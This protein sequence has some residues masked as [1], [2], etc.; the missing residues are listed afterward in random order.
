MVPLGPFG[1][2]RRVAVAVSGGA[3]STALALLAS[4][5]GRAVALVVDHRL[6]PESAAQADLTLSRLAE[7]GIQARL[8]TLSGL[9][10]GP[11]LQARART[12]RYAALTAACAEAGLV[13][14]L[15][16]HHASDQAETVALRRASGSGPAGLAGMSAVR[17]TGP[18]RLL[19][20]L[21]AIPPARLRTTLAAAGMAWIE[22][23]SN[24][25]PRFT[26]GRLRT[27][28]PPP[29]GPEDRR[30]HAE[31]RD[32]WPEPIAIHPAG[33]AVLPPGPIPPGTLAAAIW[34]VS[35]RP[36]PPGQDAVA[37][38]T[39][40][41]TLHGTCIIVSRGRRFI[42]REEAATEPPVPALP[43]ARWDGR[44]V[45]ER[46]DPAGL[47][48]G[49][50]GD[51]AP[52]LRRRSDLP[53]AVLRVFPA[54]WRDGVLWAVPHLA[55]PSTMA[56]ASLRIAFRP[57]HPIAGSP[58]VLPS[59]ASGVHTALGHPMFGSGGVPGPDAGPGE[60]VQGL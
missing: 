4:S 9:V 39:G 55:Y 3:D 58:F 36:Y 15:L 52:A 17:V 35:G 38:T 19:R 1:A 13:D 23:P 24:T 5:W 6:R 7:R 41:S 11:G 48:L 49:R 46:C 21:L 25:D 40:A 44:F 28:P 20:P 30:R 16:G 37:R 32:P 8:L 51:G 45:I 53:S 31:E 47:R 10:P 14:L 43:G 50:L 2:A 60:V 54:L 42:V 22:D 33:F 12:A 34:T 29:P 18:V 59:H 57:A 56:C 26:R 27:N